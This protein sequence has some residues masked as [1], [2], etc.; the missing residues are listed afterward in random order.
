MR[1]HQIKLASDTDIHYFEYPDI[2]YITRR[3]PD[4]RTMTL[5]IY[6]IGGIGSSK[7]GKPHSDDSNGTYSKFDQVL[8]ATMGMMT[9][10]SGH[11]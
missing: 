10:E 7:C 4:D 6:G 5:E 1:N 9:R 11:P 3:S 2:A 8:F